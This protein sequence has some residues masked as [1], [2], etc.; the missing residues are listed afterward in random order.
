MG[1]VRL[2]RGNAT[3]PRLRSLLCGRGRLLATP[4]PQ[5]APA[6]FVVALAWCAPSAGPCRGW[7]TRDARPV[8]VSPQAE[9]VPCPLLCETLFQQVPRPRAARNV[10]TERP[11]GFRPS[12][13]F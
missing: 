7:L 4:R 8:P 3:D 10:G 1:G 11:P 5:S 12:W 9:R 2:E 6:L 13:H